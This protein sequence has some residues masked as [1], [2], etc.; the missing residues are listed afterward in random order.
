MITK[1]FFSPADDSYFIFGPRGTG[2][3]TWVKS[4]LPN[5]LIINL[6]EDNVYRQYLSNPGYIQQFV[7]GNCDKH[8]IFVIDEIQKIPAILD[9][10][11]DLI[12]QRKDIQFVLTGS[13]SRKL[14]R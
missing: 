1:R 5:A 13:S 4:N 9:G 3:S 12:E 14:K 8:K 10:V 6:L 11:H 2:K 7:L